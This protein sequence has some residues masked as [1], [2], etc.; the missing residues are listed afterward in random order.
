MVNLF[1]RPDP[2]GPDRFGRTPE[3]RLRLLL[4]Y[5]ARMF[6]WRVVSIGPPPGEGVGGHGVGTPPGLRFFP[7]GEASTHRT[8]PP[9]K[10]TDR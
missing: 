4:K 6:G 9:Q 10:G 7:A 5:M 8:S 1:I 2:D 3:V